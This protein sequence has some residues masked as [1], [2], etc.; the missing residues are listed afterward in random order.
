M[1]KTGSHSSGSKYLPERHHNKITGTLLLPSLLTRPMLLLLTLSFWWRCVD[2]ND[3]S[4]LMSRAVERC[5]GGP[6]SLTGPLRGT[7]R[8]LEVARIRQYPLDFNPIDYPDRGAAWVNVG[9]SLGWDT[10][11]IRNMLQSALE[12]RKPEL[13]RALDD[14][15]EHVE[16]KQFWRSA[17]GDRK[18]LKRENWELKAAAALEDV[19]EVA[20]AYD[21]LLNVYSNLPRPKR[22]LDFERR[23]IYAPFLYGSSRKPTKDDKMV[24]KQFVE[25]KEMLVGRSSKIA[26]HLAKKA[27][28]LG[29]SETPKDLFFSSLTQV[30]EDYAKVYDIA[31][32]RKSEFDAIPADILS[33][34]DANIPAAGIN[35]KAILGSESW[36]AAYRLKYKPVLNKIKRPSLALDD[37][38]CPT[39]MQNV[40]TTYVVL[41]VSN[42]ILFPDRWVATISCGNHTDDTS[43]QNF[44]SLTTNLLESRR[45]HLLLDD[46]REEPSY[47][48]ASSQK[49]S[50]RRHLYP[51]DAAWKTLT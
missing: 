45:L 15:V 14:A 22:K 36:T 27:R 48:V 6:L 2:G 1:M 3:D 38:V 4:A 40:S 39:A 34:I 7:K 11:R 20:M 21:E 26:A 12:D 33:R 49:P 41:P 5:D 46:D 9:E 13:R 47:I 50:R 8:R 42:L 51:A 32:R 29:A 16:Q 37:N 25:L 28:V 23:P 18:N 24:A 10:S 19:E 35:K 44:F 43:D 17:L 31:E 30:I